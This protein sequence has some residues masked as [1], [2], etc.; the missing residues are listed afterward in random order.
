MKSTNNLKTKKFILICF[1]LI[2]AF[3]LLLFSSFKLYN[4]EQ[5]QQKAIQSLTEKVS[6]LEKKTKRSTYDW[7]SNSFNYLAIGNS[8]TWHGVCDYWWD[9]FGMAASRADL[10]YFHLVTEL[11]NNTHHSVTSHAY[12]FSI[13]ETM[14]H[15]R[16]ETLDILLP[17]LSESLDLITIQLG[18]NV[19]DNST[20]YSDLVELIS[21][22]KSKAPKAEIVLI[23]DFWNVKEHEE[24]K[25]QASEQAQIHFVSL[26]QISNNQEY[27]A[28]LGYIVYGSDGVEHHVEHNGVAKHPND[29]AM[30]YIAKQIFAQIN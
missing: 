16:A 26:S 13:W 12:N 2:L 22:L 24:I 19:S 6:I 30:E 5:S 27:Q 14:Y 4:H 11:L 7:S 10:D 21:F 8:I 17:V 25:E 20:F 28:G 15:D 29:K 18:E 3:G 9:E 1:V 23:G